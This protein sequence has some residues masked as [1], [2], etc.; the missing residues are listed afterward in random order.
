MT[1]RSYR[2]IGLIRNKT[3]VPYIMLI[4]GITLCWTQPCIR[5]LQ[6]ENWVMLCKKQQSVGNQKTGCIDMAASICISSNRQ[7]HNTPYSYI[8]ISRWQT[9]QQKLAHLHYHTRQQCGGLMVKLPSLFSNSSWYKLLKSIVP[10]CSNAANVTLLGISWVF[11][12]A[13]TVMFFFFSCKLFKLSLLL[14]VRL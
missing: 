10:I 6:G 4:F 11:L 7:A 8:P 5:S 13:H 3:H 1:D 9:F 12:Y 14:M 2:D